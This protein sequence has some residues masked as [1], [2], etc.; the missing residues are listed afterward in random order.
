M[1][2]AWRSSADPQDGSGP[3]STGDCRTLAAPMARLNALTARVPL[4]LSVNP[5][6]A[7]SLVIAREAQGAGE[8]VFDSHKEQENHTNPATGMCRAES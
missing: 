2:I 8:P 1:W 7:G 4:G 6:H 5:L 3:A